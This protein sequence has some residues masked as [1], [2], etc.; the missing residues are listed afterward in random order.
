[1]KVAGR[2]RRAVAENG[3]GHGDEKARNRD[4]RAEDTPCARHRGQFNV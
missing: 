1:V 4:P 2:V 3:Q